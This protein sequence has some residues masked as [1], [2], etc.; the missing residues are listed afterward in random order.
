MNQPQPSLYPNTNIT[1]HQNAGICDVFI[2]KRFQTLIIN[3]VLLC[4][5]DLKYND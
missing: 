3:P 1:G 2:M 4:H 5:S